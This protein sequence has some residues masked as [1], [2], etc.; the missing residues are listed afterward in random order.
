MLSTARDHEAVCTEKQRLFLQSRL[1]SIIPNVSWAYTLH[2]ELGVQRTR[3]TS[4]QNVLLFA[5]AIY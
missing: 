4:V 2:T 3:G 5:N 1:Q